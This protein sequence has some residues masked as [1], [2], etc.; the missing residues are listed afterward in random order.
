MKSTFKALF[1]FKMQYPE[2]EQ[3]CIRNVSSILLKK[4]QVTHS[5]LPL[6]E[7]IVLRSREILIKVLLFYHFGYLFF[8]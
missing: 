1:L 5:T 3:T 2:E 4:L 7:V 6:Q 8:D